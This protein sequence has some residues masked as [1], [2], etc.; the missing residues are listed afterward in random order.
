MRTTARRIDGGRALRG[1]MKAEGVGLQ[2]LSARTKVA[3]PAGKGVSVALLGFLTQDPAASR[4]AR[5]T[6]SPETA[7][8]IEAAL[9]VPAGTLFT[10]MEAASRSDPQPGWDDLPNVS[11]Q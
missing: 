7:D 5:E 11:A 1:A 4:H 10:R 3:D 6:C 2:T 9:G 8:L